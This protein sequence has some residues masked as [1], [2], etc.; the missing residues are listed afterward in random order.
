M[1]AEATDDPELKEQLVKFREWNDDL[2]EMYRFLAVIGQAAGADVSDV[3][4]HNPFG[5]F[6]SFQ[7]LNKTRSPDES[8][9]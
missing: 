1:G 5:F 7:K 2:M 3:D 8:R 9:P 4:R 6:S